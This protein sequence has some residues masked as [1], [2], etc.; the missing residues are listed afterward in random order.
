MIRL[1]VILS[2]MLSKWCFYWAFVVHGLGI[3]PRSWFTIVACMVA[4]GLLSVLSNEVVD[5]EM[6][7]E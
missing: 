6:P 4:I 3:Q 5:M 1:L 2:I 7:D